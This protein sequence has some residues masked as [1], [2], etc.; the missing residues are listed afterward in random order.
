MAEKSQMGAAVSPSSNFVET[1]K[2]KKQTTCPPWSRDVGSQPFPTMA[3]ILA[4]TS[5]P[6]SF[7]IQKRVRVGS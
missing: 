6:A 3:E 1:G 5:S 7:L 4:A 2:K